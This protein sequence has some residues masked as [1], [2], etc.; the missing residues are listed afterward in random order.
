MR[1]LALLTLA[2]LSNVGQLS[3]QIGPIS[4]G[5]SVQFVTADPSGACT[6][7]SPLR[8]NTTNGKLWGC[9]AGTWISISGSGGGGTVGSGT[10]GQFATYPSTGTTIGGSTALTDD[11]ANINVVSRN[12]AIGA[13]LLVPAV[14]TAADQLVGS[15]AATNGA[16]S[17]IGLSNCPTGGLQYSTS[18][19]TFSCGTFAGLGANTF[20]DNQTITAGKTLTWSAKNSSSSIGGYTDSAFFNP[21]AIFV[22]NQILIAPSASGN[23][24]GVLTAQNNELVVKSEG[25]GLTGNEPGFQLTASRGTDTGSIFALYGAG[26]GAGNT[27]A[28]S[29][30]YVINTTAGGATFYDVMDTR[31]TPSL[32]VSGCTGATL[33]TD[34]S[35][36]AG[37]ITGLPTGSCT[38]VMTMAVSTFNLSGVAHHAWTCAVSDLTTANL[39]R[40]SAST[41]TTVTLTGTSVSGDVLQ[42]G[43]CGAY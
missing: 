15:A 3:A 30:F 26:F 4:G 17:G 1:T 37:Q 21:K 20:T 5:G 24:Q 25:T 6:A 11:S 14:L 2:I 27:S 9:N 42:Y 18:T 7:N 16:T 22:D 12:L 41:T 10:A 43:P 35:N 28:N 32:N 19:H 38:I 34:S 33:A 13:G 40:V 29:A 8:Y 31:L 36:W 39:F 23:A